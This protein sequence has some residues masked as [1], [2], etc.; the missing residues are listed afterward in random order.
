M[1]ITINGTGT[2]TGISAG[3]LPDGSVTAADLATT[4]DLSNN[5]VTLPA[6][7]G[8]K[9]ESYAVICDQKTQ[10]T[11]GGNGTAGSWIRRDLNTEIS[12]SDGIVSISSNQFTLAAGNYIIKASAP[13]YRA[14]P[15]QIRLYDSTGA[16]VVQVG[17][18]EYSYQG[19]DPPAQSRSFVYARVSPSTSNV[20]EIQHRIGTSYPPQSFGK[21]ANFGVEIYTIV[22]IYKEA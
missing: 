16:A 21:A 14:N 18:T 4:L 9:F 12:D 6:G 22:E 13:S 19:N 1:A 10:N 15:H 2:I 3:G 20:Y 8:G 5:T 7:V 17:T 11:D